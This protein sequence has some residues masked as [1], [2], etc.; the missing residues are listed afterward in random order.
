M[1]F[2]S[3]HLPGLVSLHLLFTSLS[4]SSVALPF[5]TMC[6]W[7]QKWNNARW[8]VSKCKCMFE[9]HHGMQV[10][11]KPWGDP[12][13][14][15][16]FCI[17]RVVWGIHHI[18]WGCVGCLWYFARPFRCSRGRYCCF[19]CS[20]TG[21]LLAVEHMPPLEKRSCWPHLESNSVLQ[22]PKQFLQKILKK[23]FWPFHR[24]FWTT[25]GCRRCLIILTVASLAMPDCSTK[26]TSLSLLATSQKQ[27]QLLF[28]LKL[29]SVLTCR[30]RG[31][32]KWPPHLDEILGIICIA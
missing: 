21:C 13:L 18:F 7:H 3:W 24:L 28:S 27:A 6:D 20:P 16:R 11:I 22:L 30:N 23:E 29:L 17:W 12:F 5:S 25:S 14:W 15:S 10:P 8:R 31:L 32:H 2:A 26:G 1:G 19:V 9:S 4:T